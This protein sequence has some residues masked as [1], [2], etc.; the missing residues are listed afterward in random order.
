MSNLKVNVYIQKTHQNI[1]ACALLYTYMHT[2]GYEHQDKTNVDRIFMF[3]L[4]LS[5]HIH[6]YIPDG[7][8]VRA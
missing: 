2:C 8:K 3:T 7:V 5:L 4:L 6:T 1:Y